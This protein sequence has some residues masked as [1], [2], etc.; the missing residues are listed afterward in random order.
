MFRI[1]VIKF[2]LFIHFFFIGIKQHSYIGHY[3]TAW[4]DPIILR[5]HRNRLRRDVTDAVKSKPLVLH[6]RAFDK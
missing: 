3:E 4:Y 2:I 1:L 5:E 6:L